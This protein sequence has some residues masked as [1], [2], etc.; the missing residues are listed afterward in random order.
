MALTVGSRLGH[1]DVTALIGEGGMGQVYR[2]TDTQLGR[3]VALKILPDAF[4]ADPDRLARFQREA[5]VLASLKHPNIAQ[6]HGI[7]KSDDT[8]ALVLEFVEGPT[9]ADRIAKGPIP[10][11]EAL[12]IAKQIAEA[13]EA[14][15]EA[16]MIHRD[17]KPANIKV[18]ED[19]TVKVLDFGL[20]KALDT[21]PEGDPSQS[22]TLTAAATQMGVIM[23]TAAYM[24]PEQ[25]RRKPVDRRADIWGFGAVFYE[26]LTGRRA[27]NGED[28]SMTLAAVVRDEPDWDVTPLDVRPLLRRCLAKD[29]HKRLRDIGDFEWLLQGHDPADL[30]VARTGRW[31]KAGW[32][33]AA[34]LLIVALVGWLR[35][36]AP[37]EGTDLAM[38]I[39]PGPGAQL[40]PVGSLF[41]APEISP[42]GTAVLYAT[43][44]G[45]Y[46]RRLDSLHASKVPG[47]DRISN[48][49]F[50]AADSASVFYPASSA[51]GLIK[52][53]LPN[54]A[55]ELVLPLPGFSRGGSSNDD[56]TILVSSVGRLHLASP[57]GTVQA[58]EVPGLQEGR[59]QYPEFLPGGESILFQWLSVDGAKEVY[60]ASLKDGQVRQP[61]RLMTN[62]TAAR[63]T[64]AGGGNV[65]FV[66]EDYLYSQ[67]L[68]LSASALVG[69][70]RLVEEGVGSGPGM[71]V[72]RADFSVSR[73]G[74]IAWRPGA[75][76]LSQVTA[77]DRSG[78]VVETAGPPLPVGTLRLSPDESR[79]LAAGGGGGGRG[80][81]TWANPHNSIWASGLRGDSG[82]RMGPP[83]LAPPGWV[84][85]GCSSSSNVT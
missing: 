57:D 14:A 63:Y 31:G 30:P 3:D 40:S 16:G 19:G 33:A 82:R 71:S 58:V 21:T 2:A 69:D 20:A 61:V 46:V 25:A 18:R 77:F 68:D 26:M 24:S 9:L 32:I 64:P 38:S 73:S 8:Q 4:A 48:A 74:A 59:I 49:A 34:A 47:S 36:S 43:S 11:D 42:D 10:L 45:L 23:G 54:G 56:G 1:Y 12:P 17:L 72:D 52:A 85:P 60:L 78:A 76:A 15:H 29:P 62:D 41:G 83:S 35:P 22:P 79:L 67:R 66:R 51:G 27:F 53:A 65:L 13:L 84:V 6:I 75:A 50:W 28:V 39:V 44:D 55:P 70:S 81:S 80:F 37:I 7:E 5:Q